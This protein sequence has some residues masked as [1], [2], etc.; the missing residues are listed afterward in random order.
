MSSRAKRALF[1]FVVVLVIAYAVSRPGPEGPM[2]EF[3]TP[4]EQYLTPQIVASAVSMVDM[5]Q[6]YMSSHP[7]PGY[8]PGVGSPAKS[9]PPY[10]Q[11]YKRDV[12][13]KTHG[14]LKATFTV[15]PNVDPRLRFGL[16]ATPK[17]YPAWIRFSSGNANPQPDSE[18][19]ARGM[20]IKIMGVPGTKLLEADGLPPA[21]TQDFVMMNAQQFFIRNV[22]EYADFTKYLGTGF[23][24]RARY[25]YFLSGF[26]LNP[27]KWHWSDFHF[28]ELMLA[29]NTLKKAPHSLLNTKF[30]SVSAYTLG[31]QL[32]VK[33]SM[34]PCGDPP[35]AR[36][37]RDQPNFLREEMK[38]RL[39]AGTAC[40]LFMVQLQVA[41][42]NMPVEDTTVKWSEHDSPFIPVARIDIPSQEFES[43][44]ALAENMSFN[45]WHSLPEHRPIGVMNRLRKAVYLGVERYRRQMNGAQMCEPLDW[46]T[47]VDPASCEKPATV[48]VAVHPRTHF[49]IR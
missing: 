31:P 42:K 49:Y 32:N 45:P 11:P 27:M 37:D 3:T 17:S 9:G 26:T 2:G 34:K 22:T 43:N 12:H 28:R 21:Q 7:L 16:F 36:V 41:G 19:D 6:H 35:A 24:E 39:T 4:E 14:L 1:G 18:K 47:P 10:I 5:S 44:N 20:A 40:F 38:K 29:S 33:Y 46:Q 13:S 23:G 48:P 15:L 25:G 8:P 30:Y